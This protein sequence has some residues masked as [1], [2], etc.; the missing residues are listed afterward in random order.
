M[1]KRYYERR[2]LNY[3]LLQRMVVPTLI[4]TLTWDDL[5]E[6]EETIRDLHRALNECQMELITVQEEAKRLRAENV[7]LVGHAGSCDE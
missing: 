5:Q 3:P 4:H 7:F 1:R 2:E 6:A